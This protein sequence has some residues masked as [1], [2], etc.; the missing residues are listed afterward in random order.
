MS[1]YVF[2]SINLDLVGT[3]DQLPHPGETV[4]GDRFMQAPGGKGANQALAAKRAGAEVRLCGAVGDDLYANQALAELKQAGVELGALAVRGDA[5]GIAL[6]L[7]QADGENMIAVLPGANGELVPDDA[8]SMLTDIGPD[9]ILLCQQEVPA[10]SVVAALRFAHNQ[11]AKTILNIAP[12]SADTPQ[13][14]ELADI[15]I[16]NETEFAGLTGSRV[17]EDQLESALAAY[18]RHNG[19]IIIMTLGEQGAMAADG[20]EIVRAPSLKVE[21]IDAVGA[22]DT[23]C[24]YL[25]QALT[26][27]KPLSVALTFASAAGALACTRRGAQPAI[28]TRS[29]VDQALS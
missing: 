17:V 28:P 6:I 12:V 13:L 11:G 24:G 20:V 23:F 19:K 21:A 4:L 29:E 14:A 18:A 9:D 7:V 5:T 16:A 26:E 22:G 10:P 27:G 1:I 8:A 15:I 2:G 25:A 3:M